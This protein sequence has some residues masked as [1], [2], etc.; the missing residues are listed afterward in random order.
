MLPH[1]LAARQRGPTGES[2]DGRC[3][4][5]AMLLHRQPRGSAALP[6]KMK[7]EDGGRAMLPHRLAARQR[8]PTVRNEG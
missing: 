7:M 1:R 6:V 2:E 3:V 5:R 4:G 8:G